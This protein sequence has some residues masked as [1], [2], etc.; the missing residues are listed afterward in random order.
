MDTNYLDSKKKSNLFFVVQ[1]NIFT[2]LK[3]YVSASTTL[4]L[5][6]LYA[7]FIIFNSKRVREPG[8]RPQIC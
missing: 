7:V 6:L 2:L 4:F 5:K 8:S 3:N 1:I